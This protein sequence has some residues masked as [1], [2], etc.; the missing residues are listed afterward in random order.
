[1]GDWLVCSLRVFVDLERWV[2]F[3]GGL[4]PRGVGII[5]VLDGLGW[6][7]WIL[8]FGEF[9]VITMVVSL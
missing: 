2:V 6:V 4:V 7:D 3:L 8:V 9:V 5:W 1:M